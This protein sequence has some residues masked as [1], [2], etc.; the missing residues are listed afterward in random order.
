MHPSTA[1]SLSA[2]TSIKNADEENKGRKISDAFLCDAFL[3][4]VSVTFFALLSS[5]CHKIYVKRVFFFHLS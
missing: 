3:C 5:V 1:A 4:D 2:I